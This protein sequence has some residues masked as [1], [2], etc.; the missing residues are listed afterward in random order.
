[1]NAKEIKNVE[2]QGHAIGLDMPPF[3][4]AE[5]SGNH[6]QSLERA[7]A[8]VDAA[9]D[10]G[11]DAIKTQ[12]Y[13]P[14]SMTLDVRSCVFVINNASSLWNGKSLYELYQEAMLPWEWHEAIFQR[15]KDRGMLAFSTPFD[16]SAVDFL[17]TLDVPCYKIASF[18][19]TDRELLE[20][21][22]R[23]G[24]PVIMST[25]MAS[26]AEIA[27]SVEWLKQEG[28]SNL[29]LL[30]CVSAYPSKPENANLKTIPNMRTTF[31]AQTGLS[32]HTLGTAVSVAAVALGA[33]LIEKHFTLSRDEG[34]D[35]AFSLL[36]D[37]LALLRKECDEAWKA[38]GNV[39]YG[40][41]G[42]QESQERKNRRSLYIVRD[43]KAGERLLA[44]DFRS[45]R[46]GWGLSPLYRSQLIGRRLS[47]DTPRGT[48]LSWDLLD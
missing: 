44:E 22:A 36:P 34:S 43:K 16:P 13:T 17:E 11:A 37:Q 8:L 46:P 18:E 21:V 20:K 30:K 26:L 7:L 41:S 25:G 42:E 32:D 47:R 24:K 23:T 38:L 14:D 10:C 28:C 40:V 29:V 12:T 45:I 1:M 4:V 19:M 9:A 33:T 27:Q 3:I 15:A 35:A 6:N 39:S 48:P 2:I 31:H 5:L